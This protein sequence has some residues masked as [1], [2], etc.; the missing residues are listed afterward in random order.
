MYILVALNSDSA[1]MLES[2]ALWLQLVLSVD[3]HCAV[4]TKA[5]LLSPEFRSRRRPL[6]L[7]W[8]IMPTSDVT[9]L[10]RVAVVSGFDDQQVLWMMTLEHRCHQLSGL[11]GYGEPF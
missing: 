7:I 1:A 10:L 6:A 4:M 2:A 11:W 8:P 9:S 5:M 3:T